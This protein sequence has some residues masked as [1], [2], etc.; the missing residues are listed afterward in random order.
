MKK[1][2]IMTS[3]GIKTIV[4]AALIALMFVTNAQAQNNQGVTIVASVTAT[5]TVVKINQK[6]REVTIKTDDGKEHNFVASSDVKNLAQVKKGDKITVV[7]AESIAYLIRK[8]GDAALKT[9]DVAVV[10]APGAKPAGAIAQ[11]TMVSVKVTAI[12]G[13]TSS[14]TVMGPSGTQKTVKVNDPQILQGL[15]VGDIVD[16]TY[17][18]AIAIKVD[19][20]PKK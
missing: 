4:A 20:A 3:L 19:E 13:N 11:Q 5:A 8:H 16:L 18:E 1:K 2:I 12:D 17:T 15:N 9:T 10:A 6:S 14:V 7:Y